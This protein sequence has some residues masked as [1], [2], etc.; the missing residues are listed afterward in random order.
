M[1]IYNRKLSLS[2]PWMI[3]LCTIALFIPLVIISLNM[4]S[5]TF[6]QNEGPFWVFTVGLVP[7]LMVALMQFILSWA[8]FKQISK[9]SSMKIKGVLNS[10]DGEEYYAKL[11]ATAE[12]K[13]DVEGVTAS[14]FVR[15]FA[16][17]TS[18]R[19]EKKVLISAL[20]RGVKVRF[21]LPEKNF[22]SLED[23]AQKFPFTTSALTSLM[24]L[25]PTMIQVRY[26]SH[27]PYT[28]IVRVD[29]D[30]LVGPIFDNILS[31][32]TPAVHTL[33]GSSLAQSYLNHFDAEWN[34]ARPI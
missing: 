27:N 32:N 15:D 4:T 25:Y 11:I 34:T 10:R 20:K 7:G 6:F 21:L 28:S 33:A 17:P 18:L 23:Q 31:R 1:S 14:R 9:F 13:I 16:D 30:V 26:F 8:E 12:T 3:L 24:A 19:E 2:L 29:D 5:K 22:L